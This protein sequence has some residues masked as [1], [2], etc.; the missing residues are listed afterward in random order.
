[1]KP[2]RDPFTDRFQNNFYIILIFHAVLE[3][4]ILYFTHCTNNICLKSMS[5]IQLNGTFLYKLLYSLIILFRFYNV[6]ICY[7]FKYLL[8]DMVHFIIGERFLSLYQ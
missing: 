7:F 2:A 1:M 8:R 6:F 5:F 4:F 3:Y